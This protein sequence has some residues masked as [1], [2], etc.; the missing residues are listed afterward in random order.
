MLDGFDEVP[1]RFGIEC[2]QA[3]NR[4]RETRGLSGIVICSRSQEYARTK[5]PFTLGG[6]IT[7]QPL[8][9]DQIDA[10]LAAAG[11]QLI[12]LRLAI[13]GDPTIREMAR[14]PLMLSV[15][16]SAYSHSREDLTGVLDENS[17]IPRSSI[18][19]W[20]RHLFDAYVQRMFHVRGN[21]DTYTKEQTELWLGWLAR[22][23]FEFNSS[24]LLIEQLQPSWLPNRNWRWYYMMAVGFLTGLAA[25][26]LMWLF[27]QLLLLNDR[28]LLGPYESLIA[29]IPRHDQKYAYALTIIIANI[30]L[31]LIL[32]F[33]Q[34]NYFEQLRRQDKESE[35]HGWRYQ[36]HL[37]SVALVIG[38]L[39]ISTIA[40]ASSLSVASIWGI[41]EVVVFLTIARYIYGRSFR[42][43]IRLVE[44]LSWS[45]TNA[46]KGLALALLLAASSEII[47]RIINRGEIAFQTEIIIIA[48]GLILGGLRG[49]RVE[50]KN[51]P[52]Q[53]IYLSLGNSFKA[54]IISALLVGG[55]AWVLK[56]H[57]YAVITAALTFI[58]AGGLL[59]GGNV[60]KHFLVRSLLW[61]NGDIPWRLASFLDYT[62]SVAFIRKV[63]GSYIFLHRLLQKHFA[64]LYSNPT[65]PERLRLVDTAGLKRNLEKDRYT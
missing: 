2:A 22:Q 21:H 52:N 51:R 56:T 34:G 31:G 43:D 4:F 16:S 17:D 12:A 58:I 50:E 65:R 30:I 13:K 46:I 36:R 27:G 45:W 7:L 38:L 18:G 48:G 35:S 20:R 19:Y 29:Q 6:A 5:T 32:A 57:I 54:A 10:Y 47:G 25:G 44:A 53:G 14:S 42:H 41:S 40:L 64:S 60:I 55:L 62:A 49:Q 1:E 61:W 39:T 24:Q 28:H 15:M 3:I 33:L 26:I 11:S 63:G 8:R 37:A 59:G 23:M 9:D